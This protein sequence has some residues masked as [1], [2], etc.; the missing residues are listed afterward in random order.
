MP[1]FLSGGNKVH[2]RMSHI[3]EGLPYET[4]KWQS[5]CDPFGNYKRHLMQACS[6]PPSINFLHPPD[7]LPRRGKHYC[8]IGQGCPYHR[9]R[10]RC[11][12]PAGLLWTRLGTTPYPVPPQA[13]TAAI[14]ASGTPYSPW[15]RKQGG[16]LFWNPLPHLAAGPLM[17]SSTPPTL[18]P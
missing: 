17:S 3:S 16:V 11:V 10:P 2:G 9:T 6:L 14:I 1:W 18:S 8:A 15:P 12:L 13:C 7:S 5:V 4:L